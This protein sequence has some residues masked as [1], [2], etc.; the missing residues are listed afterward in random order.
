MRHPAL[1]SAPPSIAIVD[2]SLDDGAAF[3]AAAP[4]LSGH[5]FE[6]VPAWQARPPRRLRWLSATVPLIAS[7]AVAA[8]LIGRGDDARALRERPAAAVV[9]E[10]ARGQ[11]LVVSAAPVRRDGSRRTGR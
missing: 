3:P 6:M 4:L 8:L 10:T 7:A 1:F 5:G 11:A 2:E 9:P